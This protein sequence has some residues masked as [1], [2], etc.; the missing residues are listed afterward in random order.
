MRKSFA[1]VLC[2]SS[3]LAACA[4]EGPCDPARQA[5]TLEK[6]VSTYTAKAGEENEDTCQ[7]WTLQNP[8]E[9]WVSGVRQDNDGAYHHANWFFV[10]DDIFDVPDGIWSCDEH[11]FSELEAAIVGGFLFAMSTQSQGEEQRL[12]AGGA[13][14]IPPY[15]RIIGSSHVLNASPR[16]ITTVMRLTL[17]TVPA[18]QVAAK[19]VPARIQY[20]DL[21]LPPKGRSAFT[22]ECRIDEGHQKILNAPLDYHIFYALSHYHALGRYAQLE[23]AGGPRD[24]E[25]IFRSDGFGE[26]FGRPFDN[27]LDL[28]ATGA[29]GFRFTCG[30]ENPT[31]KVVRW[32]IGDQEMCVLQLFAKTDLAWDGNVNR[33][34]GAMTGTAPDGESR[35]AG[36]CELLLIP[37]NHDKLG[38]PPRPR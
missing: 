5:C 7:S 27:P 35:F 21:Q 13:V 16:D 2:S 14:R 19:L 3:L 26:N 37:W 8:T 28:A 36:P 24:G 29:R 31:D 34:T 6:A 33:G 20:V 22:T 15:S 4:G 12:P 30:F 23:L 10:P 9:L 32:G 1:L 25:V 11:K 38:G 18:D 17:S